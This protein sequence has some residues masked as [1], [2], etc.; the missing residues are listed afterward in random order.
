MYSTSL[1]VEVTHLM[2]L[3]FSNFL[4]IQDPLS[5]AGLFRDKTNIGVLTPRRSDPVSP[6]TL[7]GR[8]FFQEYSIIY[9][10][11]PLDPWASQYVVTH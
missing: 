1:I 10:I 2:Y 5:V 9:T 6:H 4:L 8:N 11:G 3:N 7:M